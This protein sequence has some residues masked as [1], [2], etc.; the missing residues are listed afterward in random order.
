M[1]VRVRLATQPLRVVSAAGSLGIKR[2][3]FTYKRPVPNIARRPTFLFF[4]RLRSNVVLR[5]NNKMAKSEKVFMTAEVSCAAR[6]L[7]QVPGMFK[8]QA[9]C[10]GE[11]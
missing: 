8:C 4:G 3:G 10:R 9:F 5:G 11:H 7:I 1:T 2:R 6:W